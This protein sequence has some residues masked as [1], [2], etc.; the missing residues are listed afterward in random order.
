[1]YFMYGSTSVSTRW[2]VLLHRLRELFL[3]NAWPH[4]ISGQM[5]SSYSVVSTSKTVRLCTPW[6]GRWIG[7]CRTT[8]SVVCPSAPHAQATEVT[9]P[10][11]HKQER[12]CSTPVRKRSDPGCS[13]KGHTRRVGADVGDESTVYDSVLQPLRIPSVIRPARRASLVVR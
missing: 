2:I 3:S 8:W 1:M 11:L 13:W 9:I 7:H 12:K 6:G 10:H 4:Y 5:L